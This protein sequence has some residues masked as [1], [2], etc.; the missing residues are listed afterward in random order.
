MSDNPLLVAPETEAPTVGLVDPGTGP[1]NGAGG[2]VPGRPPAA[3]STAAPP[4][5]PGRP[6]THGLYSK[7]A[8]SDGK[9]PVRPLT[10]QEIGQVAPATDAGGLSEADVQSLA[11]ELLAIAD[12]AAAGWLRI[13]A[14]KAKVPAAETE[15]IVAA[16]RLGERRTKWM[17]K[18]V[19]LCVREWGMQGQVSPTTAFALMMGLWAAGI[20]RATMLLQ[21]FSQ[22][23]KGKPDAA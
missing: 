12:E 16:S 14:A 4:R 17:A 21:K 20:W 2:A 11:A 3:G 15:S 18:L 23:E 9:R 10:P 7:A 19:P 22:E 1:R 6:P 5:P 8:G 13:Q